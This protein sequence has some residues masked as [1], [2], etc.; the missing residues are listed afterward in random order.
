VLQDVIGGGSV[1]PEIES[2]A[3]QQVQHL[4]HFLFTS[5]ISFFSISVNF[6]I[7][8]CLSIRLLEGLLVTLLSDADQQVPH[9]NHFLFISVISYF[10]VSVIF[11]HCFSIRLLEALLVSLQLNPVHQGIG[12]PLLLKMLSVA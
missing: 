9:L 4:T 12:L 3:D 8:C 2:I 6:Y 10:F 1:N 11:L 5:V 7:A